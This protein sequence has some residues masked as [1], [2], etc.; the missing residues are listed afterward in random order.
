[1]NLVHNRDARGTLGCRWALSWETHN[2]GDT[3][4]ELEGQGNGQRQREGKTH[5]WD[6]DSSILSNRIKLLSYD[7]AAQKDFSR[8]WD[9]FK[10]WEIIFF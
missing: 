9:Q 3:G 5:S 8:Q 1:M 6:T 10:A 4:P 2:I 7:K